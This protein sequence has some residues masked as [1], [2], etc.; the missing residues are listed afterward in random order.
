MDQ[1]TAS[2]LSWLMAFISGATFGYLIKSCVDDYIEAAADRAVTKRER[3]RRG[4][5]DITPILKDKRYD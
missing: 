2:I 1:I 3:Q 4:I 5:V